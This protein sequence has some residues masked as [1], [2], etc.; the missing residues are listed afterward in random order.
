VG[1][2]ADPGRRVGRP[3]ASRGAYGADSWPP[4]VDAGHLGGATVDGGAVGSPVEVV[5]EASVVDG[6]RS[7]LAVAQPGR[8]VQRVEVG[9][10]SSAT[11]AVDGVDSPGRR[12]GG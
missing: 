7:L 12:R 5:V 3:R 2:V 9:I 6:T 8:E 1:E 10:G 4:Q 11:G